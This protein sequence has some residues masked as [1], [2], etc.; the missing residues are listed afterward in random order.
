[1]STVGVPCAGCSSA[2]LK[3]SINSAKKTNQ[4]TFAKERQSIPTG[5]HVFELETG[6]ISPGRQSELDDDAVDKATGDVAPQQ[7]LEDTISRIDTIDQFLATAPQALDFD[8]GKHLSATMRSTK[9]FPAQGTEVLYQESGSGS[10]SSIATTQNDQLDLRLGDHRVQQAFW[11]IQDRDR[12]HIH[13]SQSLPGY[14][15]PIRDQL[16]P[17]DVRF[18]EQKKAFAVPHRSLQDELLFNY[19]LYV[20]PFLPV[21]DLEDFTNAISDNVYSHQI[22]L[23]LFQAVM[24]CAVPF[25]SMRLLEA[26]GFDNRERARLKFFEKV[27][28]SKQRACPLTSWC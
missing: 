2:E 16:D 8:L 18:L 10:L 7:T 5:L 4:R 6:I 3:C 26:E 23:I 1:M 20:H 12:H 21:L 19:T 9:D 27:R 14:I 17:E 13:K 28:V 24:F 15:Q 25:A 22:S 11:S